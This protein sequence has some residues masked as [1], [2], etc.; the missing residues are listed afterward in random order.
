V[1]APSVPGLGKFFNTHDLAAQSAGTT[2]IYRH[3][4]FSRMRKRP[5]VGR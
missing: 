5:S 4:R 3:G 1:R 2:V